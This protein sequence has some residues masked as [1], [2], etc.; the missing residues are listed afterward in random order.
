MPAD[1]HELALAL[2]DGVTFAE[3]AAPVKQADGMLTSEKMVLGKADASGRSAARS[4]PERAGMQPAK[5][6]AAEP[7]STLG[8]EAASKMA[9]MLSSVAAWISSTGK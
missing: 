2:Q 8:R 3:L 4:S 7:S 1:E 6:R 9:S 5:M